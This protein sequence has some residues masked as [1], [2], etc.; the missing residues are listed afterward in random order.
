[1]R[2]E[3]TVRELLK[4]AR[5]LTARF[6]VDLV[7]LID[8]RGKIVKSEG[9]AI[10]G[11]GIL[12]SRGKEYP[13]GFDSKGVAYGA[14]VDTDDT[15]L[16]FDGTRSKFKVGKKY[17][18]SSCRTARN[19]V[20]LISDLTDWTGYFI[21]KPRQ[22]KSRTD[23]SAAEEAWNLNDTITMGKVIAT[24]YSLLSQKDKTRFRQYGIGQEFDL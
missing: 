13:G 8:E 4:A 17:R 21:D 10:E 3:E 12:D 22:A 19:D 14:D 11:V 24:P 2:R 5:L 23:R 15:I 7:A 16:L 6:E 1:M 18:V 9:E 20:V